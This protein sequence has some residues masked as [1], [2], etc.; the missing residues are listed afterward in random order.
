M[1]M[2]LVPGVLGGD[3]GDVRHRAQE[4]GG[5]AMPLARICFGGEGGVLGRHLLD[6]F[7]ALAGGD[8]D[9]GSWRGRRT[10][11][12]RGR[13]PRLLRQRRW[14]GA[15]TPGLSQSLT[16]PAPVYERRRSTPGRPIRI[17]HGVSPSSS[18]AIADCRRSSFAGRTAIRSDFLLVKKLGIS[19]FEVNFAIRID[20]RDVCCCIGAAASAAS[21]RPGSRSCSP[22]V[23]GG[24][25]ST[26]GSPSNLARDSA[27]C[28][29][30]PFRDAA[31]RLDAEMLGLRDPR[32]PRWNRRP[33]RERHA[34]AVAVARTIR[35]GLR[36]LK[37]GRISAIRSSWWWMRAAR[38]AKRGS[39]NSFGRSIASAR[40]CQNFSGDDMCMAIHLQSAHSKT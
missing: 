11:R 25:D 9:L 23:G 37:I 26:I 35:R 28:G 30:G 32:A 6:L 36:V 18:A 1:T 3:E 27:R 14:R 40:P 15:L 29:T 20:F 16:C 33:P 34:L 4:V 2:K 5:V 8:D 7:L 13:A 39:S 17:S 31:P 12:C 21:G 10:P 38:S 22:S 19:L 24:G